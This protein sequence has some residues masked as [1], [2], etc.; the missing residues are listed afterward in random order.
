L[1]LL[2]VKK[3]GEIILCQAPD[4]LPFPHFQSAKPSPDLSPLQPAGKL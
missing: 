3:I 1:I 4:T 2:G